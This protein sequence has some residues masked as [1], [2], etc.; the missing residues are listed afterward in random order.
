MT[1]NLAA[2]AI[3]P[4]ALAY[5]GITAPLR[6]VDEYNHFFR[7][8]QVLIG[9]MIANHAA[10]GVVGEELPASLLTLAR[11]AA[12]FPHSPGI[13][14]SSAQFR[15]ASRIPLDPDRTAIINFPNSA[16]SRL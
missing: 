2:L 9:R 6:G 16:L 10:F 11:A 8:Y 12:D 15:A 7:A 13:A 4:F 3:F 1:K 5:S 14:S